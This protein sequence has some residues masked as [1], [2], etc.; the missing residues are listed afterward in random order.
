VK[1]S[2]AAL[3]HCT[4][5]TAAPVTV[6]ASAETDGDV[7]EGDLVCARCGAR[8]AIRNSI[9]R[10]A[11]ADNYAASFGFQWHVHGRTQLDELHS[12]R[13]NATRF[14]EVT[15]WRAELHG[16]RILEAGCGSG[17]FTPI[18]AA[19]G[20]EVYTF[21]YS[22]A[23]DSN[24]SNH[25]SAS[26]VHFLQAD[27]YRLPFRPASFDKVYCFGVLQHCPD[28]ARAFRTLV[29]QLAP[30]GRIAIDVYSL[31]LRSLVHPKYWLRPVTS[32]MRPDRLHRAI[33]HAV[34]VLLPV[35]RWLTDSVPLGRYVAYLVPVAYHEVWRAHSDSLSSEQLIEM[36]VLDTFDWYSPA[37]D[38]PQTQAAV[39][40][41]FRDCDLLDVEVGYGANGVIARGMKREVS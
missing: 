6:M 4:R 25:R 20:A 24:L 15:G 13:L 2:L 5:C 11:G 14:F 8:F 37:H 28:P 7:L 34:P 39:A 30:G 22:N 32:R 16:E 12:N 17:R 36:S 3:L 38:K 1:R 35:K 10:F 9:P 26:N 19:T 33:K 21:D 40:R 31:R 23:V 27:I 41:W 18:A 29:E